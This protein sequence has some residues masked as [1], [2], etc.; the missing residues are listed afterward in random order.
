MMKSNN[1]YFNRLT[2]L[3]FV[4]LVVP[5]F[6]T[7]IHVPTDEEIKELEMYLGMSQ[8]DA[9]LYNQWRGTNGGSKLSGRADLWNDGDLENNA[10]FGTSG[11][12]GL[13]GNYR[14][15][16]GGTFY[17]IG[18]PG[19]FWSS[20]ESNSNGA[21]YRELSVRLQMIWDISG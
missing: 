3:L 12:T 10:E 19:Y 18:Y 8:L 16:G 2:I 21:W 15:D 7:I 5:V 14:S 13:P 1:I 6:A 9:D 20:T 4:L 11:F 17:P